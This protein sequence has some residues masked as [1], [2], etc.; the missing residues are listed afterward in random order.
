MQNLSI[1]LKTHHI[2]GDSYFYVLLERREGV[3]EV[4][5]EGTYGQIGEGNFSNPYLLVA[6]AH[7][8]LIAD[9]KLDPFGPIGNTIAVLFLTMP[10]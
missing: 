7:F 5:I 10:T 8:P 2:F 6:F 9:Q 1:K 4:A 3:T